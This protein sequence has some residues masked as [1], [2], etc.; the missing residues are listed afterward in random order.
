LHVPVRC[1]SVLLLCR[2][3]VH[4]SVVVSGS[5][6]VVVVVIVVAVKVRL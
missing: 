1:G 3:R 5:V 2:H 4:G 6:V